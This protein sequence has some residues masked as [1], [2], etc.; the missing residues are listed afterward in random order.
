MLR[1]IT[2]R[3]FFVQ[4][5]EKAAWIEML[6]MAPLRVET[7]AGCHSYASAFM[8]TGCSTP[9]PIKARRKS[10]GRRKSI[11]KFVMYKKLFR[12]EKSAVA[13]LKAKIKKMLTHI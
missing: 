7:I 13:L 9:D 5:M 8:V 3:I 2:G 10:K 6:I 4:K 11:S 1:G 12:L